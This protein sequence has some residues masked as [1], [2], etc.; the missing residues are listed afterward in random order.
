MYLI[1]R[2]IVAAR[3]SEL[4]I[5][6]VD[7]AGMAECT[8]SMISQ[9]LS[10]RTN[11]STKLQVRVAKALGFEVDLRVLEVA[12]QVKTM[13][14][15]ALKELAIDIQTSVGQS[16]TFEDLGREVARLLREHNLITPSRL[17][18]LTQASPET[19]SPMAG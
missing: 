6:Q 3:M 15:P 11:L 2:D 19:E 4:K 13:T 18:E 16:Q 1:T 5:N 17:A 12:A 10:G 7:L 8:P 9:F 14:Y